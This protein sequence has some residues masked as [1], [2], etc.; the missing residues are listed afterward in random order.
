M[1]NS[2]F[3]SNKQISK[4]PEKNCWTHAMYS[5]WAPLSGYDDG[6]FPF[7]IT[8]QTKSKSQN[9]SWIKLVVNFASRRLIASEG[10]TDLDVLGTHVME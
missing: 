9:V 3:Q 7:Q 5:V 2:D 1:E 8:P 6:N 4:E 10:R